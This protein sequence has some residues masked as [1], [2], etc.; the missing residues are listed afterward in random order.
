MTDAALTAAVWRLTREPLPL[1]GQG[2]TP[3]RFEALAAVGADDL[4]VAKLVEPHHDAVAILA[5]L[6]G[7]PK[8]DSLFAVWAAEP[9]YARL[10]A[11]RTDKGWL[12]S[13]SKAFCSGATLV[14]D[15][16]VTAAAEDG[17]RLFRL[18]VSAGLSSAIVEVAAHDWVGDG[19]RRAGTRSLRLHDAPADAIGGPGAYPNR[20][21][22]WHGAVGVA[23]CW[24]G[25]AR[26]VASRLQLATRSAALDPYRAA[27]LGAVTAALDA[28]TAQL[29]AVARAIDADPEDERGRARRDAQSVRATVVAAAETVLTRTAH[30]LGP[31]PLA[32]DAE[33]AQR[34][35]DLQVFIRQH[36]AERDLADLG[37]LVVE[38]PPR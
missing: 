14:T 36:H 6:G 34:V 16:L 27:H 21:G 31:A 38:A 32:F 19:M 20:P 3:T 24:L 26:A 37:R 22:F 18:D 1:P 5:D 25:G 8:P 28:S 17:D 15:A 35:A 2:E 9:P 33:H 7:T 11:R 4:C 30:A 12:L 13:G 29:H 10:C 23:A